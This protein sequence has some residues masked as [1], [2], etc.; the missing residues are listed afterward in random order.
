MDLKIERF[1]IQPG[2]TRHRLQTI[3]D[4]IK[5]TFANSTK[6]LRRHQDIVLSSEICFNVGCCQSLSEQDRKHLEWIFCQSFK[7][8][9]L[10]N[11]SK[12]AS[13]TNGEVGLKLLIIEIGPRL[14]FSTAWSTNAVS[15][16]QSI[17]L[18]NVTRIEQSIRYLIERKG[19]DGV[20]SQFSNEEKETIVKLLHDPMTEC[21]YTQPLDSFEIDVKHEPC[22]EI[23][24]MN[25]GKKAL[26]EANVKLGLSFDD[27]DLEY[28][29]QMFKGKLMRNPTSVECFDLAQS[30][31][32]HSRH[33]FFKGKIVIDNECMP[34]T[35]M[36]MVMNTQDHTND[37][38]V[39]KFSDNSSAIKGY[40]VDAIR[41]LKSSESSHFEMDVKRKRHITLTAET[42]NFPTGVAP[43][44]G[45]TTGTGGRIRDNHATGIG[46]HVV[47]GTAGY[48]FGNL[49]IPGYKLPWEKE[50]VYPK[51]FASP[52]SIAIE[53]SNGASD[54]GNKFGEPVI[55]GFARSFGLQLSDEER[56][57]WIKPIMFSGGIGSIEAEHVSKIP[58]E[59]GMEVVKI[60]G[61]VYR[62]GVGGGAASSVQVQGDNAVELDFGAVQRGD[63]EMEQKLNRLIRACIEMKEDNPIC[64]IHD[65]GAGG[66]GNVLKEI[67]DPAGAI[68]RTKDFVLGD[69][70]ISTLELWGAEYQES[71][72]ILVRPEHKALLK[73]I[74]NREK[75]PV[76]FVGTITGDGKIVLDDSKSDTDAGYDTPAKKAKR[77]YPVDLPL[78]IVLG[79]MPPKTFT[80]QRIKPSLSALDIPGNLAVNEALHRVLRL[81]SVASKRYLTNKVD[82]CVTGLIA[83]QQCVGPLHTP[84]SDV[85]V[86]A[87]SMFNTVGVA[88]AI[89]EQP[90][91]GLIDPGCGAR[92]TLGEALTNL[93]F[94]EIS[95]VK[96]I[97]C[98]ANWMWPAKLPGEA[99]RL[100]DA[101]NAMCKSFSELGIAVDGGK[102]S[103][104][105]A[106]RIG[107]NSIVK[108][109]GSLVLSMYVPCPDIRNTVTP[110]L[111]LNEGA[112]ALL[113][114][115]FSEHHGRVGGS[116]LAQ[117]FGQIG[118]ES[119]DMDDVKIFKNG[120]ETTQKLVKAGM[121]SAGHDVSDGGVITTILEMAFSGNRGVNVDF[122][123]RSME[124][125][126]SAVEFL[127]AEELGIVLSVR[128]E[129]VKG[130]LAMYEDAGVQCSEVGYTKGTGT[131]AAI[132]V[133]VNGREV[134][135]EKMVVLRDIWEET[136]FQL[137][138]LQASKDC[139]KQEQKSLTSR[140]FPTYK[141]SFE[142]QRARSSNAMNRTSQVESAKPKVAVIREEGSNGDREMASTL[143]LAGFEV[144]DVTMYDICSGKISLDQFRGLV[145]VGGFS[146]ADVFGSAKGWAAVARFNEQAR[147]ELERFR[148]RE[149]TFS[150]GVCNGCQLMA[151]LGWVGGGAEEDEVNN[152]SSSDWP[153][154]GTCFTH[155]DSER[156]ECRFPT[157]KIMQSPSIMLNG[158][159]DS[160]LGI[161]IA[162]GEGRAEFKSDSTRQFVLENNLAPIRYVNEVGNVTTEYPF[163]PNGSPHGIAALC[164]RDGRHLAMMPHPERCSLLWQWPY[165]PDDWSTTLHASPWLQMFHN[166]YEWCAK[167]F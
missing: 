89:G 76:S 143:F 166:A 67:A 87:L 77:Q 62:I 116:A 91:K 125:K 83:Q 59:K 19:E 113:Y 160:T 14:N 65:Q 137:E 150:L 142:P 58:A 7:E 156:F 46:A 93:V 72:A 75:A 146:F 111:K 56:I 1:Y 98:S 9:K 48:C 43:F 144:W 61:P 35:L 3:E 20:D 165:V 127:F 55:T 117:V 31:S 102:D 16:C 121:I 71:D 32:E 157:V 68:I 107:D 135:N 25:Q 118:N 45:A 122:D 119:P 63:A 41:P 4:K 148:L 85:A 40:E 42:H 51:N 81:P 24:I 54:Y 60:G 64:S 139:V 112:D 28:Y 129:H 114:V 18:K 50:F 134:L 103:L 26:E 154:Q 47:A 74:S 164:S 158:M 13:K 162:H 155:N 95:H 49:N 79:K 17:G 10:S 33:W 97:K 39:I 151:L 120:F 152:D 145:F 149:D 130:V 29:Y 70:T 99:A 80:S 161:W 110:D 109:P 90:I 73:K 159:E 57:E 23:D 84:V 21:Q 88:T 167:Q 5:E 124:R 105:M 115:K 147:E 2:L 6:G 15:V 92:M 141:L 52:L 132:S 12:I 69:P 108:A 22:Y 82:R 27:W 123:I 106:A 104:S 153:E 131:E 36:K 94:A 44:P 140:G 11:S 34:E 38:S 136:S 100:Y 133:S 30:N 138:L 126:I 96:D 53:A 101:C 37:N 8:D 78:D 86:T 163:N 128:K 66:N